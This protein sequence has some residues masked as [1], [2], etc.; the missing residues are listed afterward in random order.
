LKENSAN[1]L[2][3]AMSSD[4]NIEVA[5]AARKLGALEFLRKPLVSPDEI[6]IAIQMAMDRKR[7]LDTNRR[8]SSSPSLPGH[9]KKAC[10]DGIV[11]TAE[12]DRLVNVAAKNREIPVCIFGETGTG[13]E[14]FAKLVHKR[15]C[16]RE[17]NIPFVS[18]NC[19]NLNS[20]LAVSLLFGHRKGA[21]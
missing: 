8:L 20:D 18:V 17:G 13:K 15:R 10:P 4:P 3:I 6:S 16:L 21:F 19:A 12:Q 2:P 5:E 14:E 1:T 11:V 9:I 7:L